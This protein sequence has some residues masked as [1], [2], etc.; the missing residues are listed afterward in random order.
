MNNNVQVSF[1]N[2]LKANH[3]ERYDGFLC[4]V[5]GILVALT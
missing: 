1:D 5:T 3:E 4:I 2:I